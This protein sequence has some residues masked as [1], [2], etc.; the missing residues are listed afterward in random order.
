[1]KPRLLLLSLVPALA[2]VASILGLLFEHA[3]LLE[4]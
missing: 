1:M 4:R 2:L 3:R